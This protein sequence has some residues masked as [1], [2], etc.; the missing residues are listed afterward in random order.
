M[1]PTL[2]LNYVYD[3]KVKSMAQLKAVRHSQILAENDKT[4][5]ESYKH[6]LPAEVRIENKESGRRNY[7]EI[8][9]RKMIEL[10]NRYAAKETKVEVALNDQ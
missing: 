8:Q 6:F 1:D 4:A 2:S 5:L 7:Q 10:K 9:S 3:P